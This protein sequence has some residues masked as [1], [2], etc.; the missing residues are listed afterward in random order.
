MEGE[1][2]QEQ[3]QPMRYVSLAEHQALQAQVTALVKHINAVRFNG[4]SI[5]LPE[6]LQGLLAE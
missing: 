5:E 4:P 2:N 3:A 6:S 1:N